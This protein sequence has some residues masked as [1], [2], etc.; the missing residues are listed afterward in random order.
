MLN[1][2][3]APPVPFAQATSA[4]LQGLFS[5]NIQPMVEVADR[6]KAGGQNKAHMDHVGKVESLW[7]Y[8]VKSMRGEQ[9]QA[10]FASFSGILGDRICA[11]HDT[12]APANFP[13]L[14]AR[15]RAHMLLFRPRF[16]NRSE[17]PTNANLIVETPTGELLDIDDPA[18]LRLLAADLDARHHISLM[19]SDRALTDAQPVSLFSIQTARQLAGE[20]GIPIDK[21][22]FRANIY[23]DLDTAQ[24]FSEDRF[25]GHSLQIGTEVVLAILDRD[26]RCKIIT[27][28]P[29][30]SEADPAVIKR[31]AQAHQ[32]RAGIYAAVQRA[33]TI[34]SGD[35]VYLLTP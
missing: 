30:T 33:G 10:V 5:G 18:L 35:A 2:A 8:P 3:A 13:Y 26:P 31:L 20:L 1:A 12:A 15:Q 21:R 24:G 17:P 6:L 7:R 29:D 14:T 4:R 9:Q 32:T 25:V 34:H 22:R 27:F 28:D 11:L 19:R 16:R 23:L